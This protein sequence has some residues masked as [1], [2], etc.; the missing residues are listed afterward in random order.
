M[1]SI[2]VL[3]AWRPTEAPVTCG[4]LCRSANHLR[5][6]VDQF[7]VE[8]NPRYKPRDGLTFCNIFAWDVSRALACEIPHWWFGDEQDAN[9]THT[10]LAGGNGQRHGWSQVDE[11][12]AQRLARE[13]R[14]VV[15]SWKNPN[16]KKPGHIA[17]LLPSPEGLGIRIAQAGTRNLFDRPVKDGFGDL[18]YL[19]FA[20]R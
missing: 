19:L 16:P 4:T 14:P 17:L 8:N 10:W 2:R 15:A 20:H 7:D 6:V 18:P 9:Q 5:M 13:G 11:F 1:E 12:A 3:D